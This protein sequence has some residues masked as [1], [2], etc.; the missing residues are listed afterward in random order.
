MAGRE[1]RYQ[2]DSSPG[3]DHIRVTERQ[4]GC[5]YSLTIENDCSL[6]ICQKYSRPL[7]QK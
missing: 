4:F 3:I 5:N 2:Q 7:Y 6:F 1:E